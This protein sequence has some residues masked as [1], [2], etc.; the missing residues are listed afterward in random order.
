[1]GYPPNPG[2]G[3]LLGIWQPFLLETTLTPWLGFQASEAYLIKKSSWYRE[4]RRQKEGSEEKSQSANLSHQ[5]STI[6][7]SS[8]DYSRSS[9]ASTGGPAP[10]TGPWEE[11]GRGQALGGLP[12]VPV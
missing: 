12:Y 7:P 6:P 8:Q 3:Y 4:A 11:A 1:M 10:L 5:E 9:H 2:V